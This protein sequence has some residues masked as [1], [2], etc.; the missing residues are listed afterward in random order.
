MGDWYIYDQI[1]TEIDGTNYSTPYV[2]CYETKPICFTNGNDCIKI[3]SH[4]IPHF[5]KHV[6][7]KITSSI[8]EVDPAYQFWGIKDLMIT[9]KLCN[10]K[11]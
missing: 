4:R 8:S 9:A 1:L 7:I 2:G 5:S 3:V 6:N 10:F 11:C